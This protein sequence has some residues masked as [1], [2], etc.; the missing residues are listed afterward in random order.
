MELVLTFVASARTAVKDQ[1]PLRGAPLVAS[2]RVLDCIL[3]PASVLPWGSGRSPFLDC[4]RFRF[5]EFS[6]VLEVLPAQKNRS[7]SP[8]PRSF[9]PM[10]EG[11]PFVVSFERFL[12][13]LTKERPCE[14]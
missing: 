12:N 1:G 3:A 13:S 10:R 14:Q 4:A 9:W 2:L 7:A 8:V 6:V 11:R 5:Y